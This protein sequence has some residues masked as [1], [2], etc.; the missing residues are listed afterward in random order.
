VVGLL[1]SVTVSSVA[2]TAAP[3]AN[4]ARPI[5]RD[6]ACSWPAVTG[7]RSRA[8]P[9]GLRDQPRVRARVTKAAA[10]AGERR[11]DRSCCLLDQ[12][13]DLGGGV[14]IATWLD[15]ISI[16]VAPMR[17]ANCRS[18]SGGIAS[19]F[20]ATRCSAT[21]R[22]RPASPSSRTRIGP[23]Q[24]SPANRRRARRRNR[25]DRRFHAYEDAARVGTLAS[26]GGN[27]RLRPRLLGDRRHQ[28]RCGRRLP[29]ARTQARA[30]TAG[31]CRG[32][33][34]TGTVERRSSVSSEQQENLDAILR[35]SAFPVGS[36]VNE[37]RRLLREVAPSHWRPLSSVTLP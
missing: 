23:D 35:Q 6:T 19:S 22:S 8:H 16:V 7:T 13:G 31:D 28:R 2:T 21:R 32:R 1:R 11:A 9:I 25:R 17:C 26:A 3:T 36:D 24:L 10:S 29:R 18:A 14:T 4:A 34:L 37:Q 27:K 30:R 12:F 20:W 5:S 15:G 33:A